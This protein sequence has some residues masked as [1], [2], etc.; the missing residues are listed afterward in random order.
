MKNDI[1][2]LKNQ[3]LY[4]E[5][6]SIASHPNPIIEWN[7][8]KFINFASNDYLGYAFHPDIQ[9]AA[10][11]AIDQWGTGSTAS[12]LICGSLQI[13]HNLEKVLA[14]WKGTESALIFASGFQANNGVLSTLINKNDTVFLDRLCHASLIDGARLS[15]AKIRVY[16]HLDTAKLQSLLS[17]EKSKCWIITES[18]FSMDGDQADIQKLQDIAIQHSATLIIDE[19]HA[20]GVY[21][22]RGEGLVAKDFSKKQIILLGT[23]SKALGSQGGF[24]CANHETIALLINHARSFIYSTAPTPAASAAA[25]KAIEFIQKESFTREALWHKTEVIRKGLSTFTLPVSSSEGPI[26]PIL[27]GTSENAIKLAQYF[28]EQG[29]F[30]PAIRPPTVPTNSSRLRLTISAAHSEAHIDSFI[31]ALKTVQKFEPLKTKM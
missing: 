16:P 30:I 6:R 2:Y 13:H 20:L 22:K 5:L 10:K 23:L 4:R 21:G 3:N 12:R 26:I 1:A 14:Q 11:Q 17:K 8:K 9:K 25:H 15:G 31:R 7:Q 19:A 18:V 28:L 24:V 29:I 27:V